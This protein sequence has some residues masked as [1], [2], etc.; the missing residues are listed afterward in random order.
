MNF[1]STMLLLLLVGSVPAWAAQSFDKTHSSWTGVL[2]QYQSE[3]G[4]VRYGALKTDAKYKTHA[5]TAY[6]SALES[7]SAADFDS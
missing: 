3:N 4:K 1:R 6:L 5:F 2:N 7:V